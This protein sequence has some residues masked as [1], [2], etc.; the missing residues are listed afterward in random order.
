M[1]QKINSVSQSVGV[2]IP[3]NTDHAVSVTLPTWASVVGYEE[4]DQNVVL[5][6]QTGYPR[7]FIHNS[8]QKL[9]DY[10]IQEYGRVGLEGLFIF[11]SYTV[12]QR[13]KK[14]MI[15]RIQKLESP[16]DKGYK[17]VRIVKLTTSAPKC[18]NEMNYRVQMAIGLVFFPKQYS[19]YGKEFWQ[20]SGEGIS[21][22]LA[23]YL[24]HEFEY[25]KLTKHRESSTENLEDEDKKFVEEKFGRNLKFIEADNA[26]VIIRKRIITEV[27]QNNKADATVKVG[28]ESDVFLYPSGMSSIYNVHNIWLETLPNHKTVVFGFPY[29]DTLNITKKFGPGLIHLG[30]GSNEEL[31]WL[32]EQLS[33][34][35]E[36]IL[37]LITECPGNPL[38][39]TPNLKKLRAIADKHSFPVAIDETV[40]NCININA[41]KYADATCSSLTKIFS[42]DSNVMGG[43]I[44]LNQNSKFYSTMKAWLNEHYENNFWKEDCLY[45]ERNSRD[46]LQRNAKTN[47]NT[48]EVV[49]LFEKYQEKGAVK[50]IFHPLTSPSK[51]Y[52]DEVKNPNGGYGGLLSILFSTTQISKKFYDVLKLSKGPSLG[53]NFTLVCPYT[54]LAHYTELE[55]VKEFGVDADLV[56]ISIGIEPTRELVDIIEEAIL[57]AVN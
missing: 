8:I 26:N 7:F 45:L 9:T 43:S 57:E 5:K 41:Y 22:R 3:N 30:N 47:K 29:V 6:M 11:P 16:T 48:E 2:P 14:F 39:R 40:G 33:S 52:Y 17:K 54:I 56:R 27:Q 37:G 34:G 25:E 55:E 1:E 49:K 13:C 53:T 19:K 15:Q 21:S 46:F 44:V 18:E 50:Q 12:S 24:L 36:K 20:H 35:K 32:D 10:L 23:E 28:D 51:K 38:L 42:G 4:G 31:D